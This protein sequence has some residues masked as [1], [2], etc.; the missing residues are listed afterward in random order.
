MGKSKPVVFNGIE[1]RTQSEAAKVLGYSETTIGKYV[2][3][4]ITEI[5]P[6]CERKT[7]KQQSIV[8]DGV[9][10]NSI[11]D[12]E[13]KIYGKYTSRLY[14]RLKKGQTEFT[15]HPE[16]IRKNAVKV[17]DSTGKEYCSLAAMERA[18]GLGQGTVS[19]RLK[20]GVLNTPNRLPSNGRIN[21]KNRCRY[22]YQG[23]VYDSLNYAMKYLHHG[24]EWIKGHCIEIAEYVN[25]DNDC[26]HEKANA[27]SVFLALYY[28]QTWN[29]DRIIAECDRR[30]KKLFAH[31]KLI[32]L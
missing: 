5:E 18:N 27:Y 23:I 17:V 6:R 4:G 14:N 11:H 26:E 1:Y 31:G 25:R 15:A 13:M 28:H 19:K 29:E 2:K 3:S 7:R 32:K 24:R 8:V 12:A 30:M 20:S 22:W 16:P 21:G 10:Y 9:E